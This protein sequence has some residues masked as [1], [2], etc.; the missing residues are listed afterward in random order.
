MLSKRLGQQAR[1]QHAQQAKQPQGTNLAV[2]VILPLTP[3]WQREHAAVQ[4]G[5]SDRSKTGDAYVRRGTCACLAGR[6]LYAGCQRASATFQKQTLKLSCL[7]TRC[8]A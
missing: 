6:Y 4:P 3:E 2:D 1:A 8:D 7:S 5:L